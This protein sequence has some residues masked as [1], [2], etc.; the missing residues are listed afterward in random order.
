M[1][2]DCDYCGEEKAQVK[3]PN[4]NV[5]DDWTEWNV[6]ITCKKI[7]R[8]QQ[9]MSV[10]LIMGDENFANQAKEKISELSRESGKETMSVKIERK[11]NL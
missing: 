6:C 2:K 7:I 5:S 8:E 9:K 10:G 4:P 11:D 3:I 1:N